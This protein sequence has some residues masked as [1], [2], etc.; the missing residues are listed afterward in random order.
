MDSLGVKKKETK[1]ILHLFIIN[2]N[3][4]LLGV[5]KF[6]VKKCES[7]LKHTFVYLSFL[8]ENKIFVIL[9]YVLLSDFS[10]LQI[11]LNP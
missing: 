4:G 9:H 11:V 6:H 10:L 5:K 1:V 3:K 8:S 2:V 7:R